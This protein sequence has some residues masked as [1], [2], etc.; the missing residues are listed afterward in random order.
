LDSVDELIDGIVP[1]SDFGTNDTS[2][3]ISFNKNVSRFRKHLT[4]K[5]K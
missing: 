2:Y 4:L 3:V 5:E 1:K